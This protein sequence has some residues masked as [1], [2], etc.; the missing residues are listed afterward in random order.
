MM[1][2]LQRLAKWRQIFASWQ[3]GTR[4]SD[5]PEVQAVRDQREILLLLRAEVNALTVI[6]LRRRMMTQPE[7]EAALD[8]EAEHLMRALEKRFP[9]ATAELDG[10]HVDMQQAEPWWSKFPP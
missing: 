5:D 1:D 2:A 6:M 7:F 3:L 4:P 9:G 10:M 8:I